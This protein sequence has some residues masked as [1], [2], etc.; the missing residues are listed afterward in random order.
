VRLTDRGK[1]AEGL[2]LRR[3]RD[4]FLRRKKDSLAKEY[5]Q[6]RSAARESQGS[7]CRVVRKDDLRKRKSV[8]EG[9]EERI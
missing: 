4:L 8:S 6:W 9:M 1:E 2:F 5:Y 3:Q 7:Q